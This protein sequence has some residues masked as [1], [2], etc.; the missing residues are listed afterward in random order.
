[1]PCPVHNFEGCP[2]PVMCTRLYGCAIVT[3]FTYYENTGNLE[4]PCRLCGVLIK[5]HIVST[6]QDWHKGALICPGSGAA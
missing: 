1:M 4:T 3:P 2:E 5:H 6:Q